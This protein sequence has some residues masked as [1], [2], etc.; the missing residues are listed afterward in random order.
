MVASKRRFG[1]FSQP[2]PLAVGDN[3]FAHT[4]KS[5]FLLIKWS[6]DRT[7]SLK[8]SLVICSQDHLFQAFARKITYKYLQAYTKMT[9]IT[10]TL[11]LKSSIKTP[12]TGKEKC[13]SVTSNLQK[14]AKL[15]TSKT[16]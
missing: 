1:L 2:P 15:C 16:I 14:L 9:L 6:E 11:R 12:C 4:T 5:I 8:L 10:T 13:I 3:S 7:V